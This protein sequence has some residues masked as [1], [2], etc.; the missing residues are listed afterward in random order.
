MP[1]ALHTLGPVVLACAAACA[2]VFGAIVAVRRA[3]A[4]EPELMALPAAERAAL[5]E[6]TRATLAGPCRTAEGPVLTEH[7]RA[8]AELIVRFPECE[9]ECRA[10]AAHHMPRP[11]R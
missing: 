1:K 3:S 2:V 8:Q 7:C 9:A 11:T 4:P 10:L 5:Y 6:R